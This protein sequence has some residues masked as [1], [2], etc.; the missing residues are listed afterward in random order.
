MA[1]RPPKNPTSRLRIQDSDFLKDA[2][3]KFKLANDADSNQQQRERDDIAFEDGQQWSPDLLL[4]RQGQQPVNGMP[5]VPARPTL[6]INKVREPVQNTLNQVRQADIGVE[7]VP[8]DDFGDLGIVPDEAEVRLREGITRRIQ[9]DSQA[10][11][12]RIWAFKRALIAGRGYYLVT[13]KYLP[14]ATFDQ[15]VSIERIYHQESVVGDPSREKPD[16]S[17]ATFW[18][19]STYCDWDGFVSEY[20]ET[21]D[22]DPNPFEGASDE[23]FMTLVETYPNWFTT[24]ED[25]NHKQVRITYYWYTEA[26]RRILCEL[27]NGKAVWKDQLSKKQAESAT[28]ERTVLD[29][30]IKFCKIAGGVMVVEE[31]DWP[32]PD[33]PIIQV[34]GDEV[35]PYDEQKRYEGMVRPSRDAQQGENYLISKYV[36]KQ[37]LAP[38]PPLMVDPEAIDGYEDWFKLASTRALPYLPYRTYDDYGREFKE[39]HYPNAD[40]N[41]LGIMQGIT[42]FDQFIRSTTSVPD[43]T[44]GNVDASL[45]SARAIHAVVAN[46]QTSTSGFLSNLGVAV[47]YEG[48]VVNNLLYPIYGSR[49]GRLIRVLTGDGQSQKMQIG[50]PKKAQLMRGA[51]AA[52]KLTPDANFNEIVKLTRNSENRRAQFLQMFSELLQANPQQMMVGGD[53]FYKNMDIPEAKI[54]ADR[55]RVMLAP[56]VQQQIAAE[57]QGQPFDPVAQAKIGA[58]T[59]Q[60]QHAEAALKELDGIANGKKLDYQKAIDTE[61][62]KQEGESL[63]LQLSSDKE[64][65]LKQMDDAT[66]IR[67]AEINAQAKIGVAQDANALEAMALGAGHAHE[68]TTAATQHAHD[69]SAAGAQAAHDQSMAQDQQ[70]HEQGMADRQVAGQIVTQP[71]AEPDQ[72]SSGQ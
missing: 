43:S 55:Q 66:K 57:Q 23:D 30:Q 5:A 26:K 53:L 33:M 6:V 21:V 31:T 67:V 54:L 12:A 3:R 39:P 36:E 1:R 61:R 49:P 13:T 17:D 32:G 41:M 14:G 45:R 60:L 40:P 69:A 16:G 64:V 8:A 15:E 28:Q 25:G 9:R 56:P 27:P 58:L 2:R 38:I 52:A 62:L 68:Q 29:K 18:F 10:Q 20:P 70:Q 46:A 65:A 35:L 4:A 42:L 72:A 59:E 37:G 51:A 7:I 22:G 63:R 50:D 71:P 44:L 48:K 34:I 47:A 19:V 24:D 11:D